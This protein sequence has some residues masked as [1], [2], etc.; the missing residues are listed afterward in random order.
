MNR[1]RPARMACTAVETAPPPG[2][3]V[4]DVTPETDPSDWQVMV[5]RV[6]IDKL[7]QQHAQERADERAKG[8]TPSTRR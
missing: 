5:A 1:T 4:I 6:G 2:V 3:A 7:K 8:R